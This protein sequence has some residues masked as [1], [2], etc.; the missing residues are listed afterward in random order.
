MNITKFGLSNFRV[1]KEHFD[2]DL[3]P[4]MV[5]TGPNNSGKSS[6]S[7]A[8]LLLKENE[9]EINSDSIF[10]DKCLNYFDGNHDL[11]HHSL[12]INTKEKHT[13]FSFT[14][15]LDYKFY[16]AF[17]NTG[18]LIDDYHISTF[19]GEL[20]IG[21]TDLGLEYNLPNLIKYF[22]DRI[23]HSQ[24]YQNKPAFQADINVNKIIDLVEKLK[25]ID[26]NS[27]YF[28]LLD[29]S[30]YEYD[31]YI[32]QNLLR[33]HFNEITSIELS[34]NEI[35]YL[36]PTSRRGFLSL[37]ELHYINTIKE[38]LKRAYS[39][40]DIS[41]FQ[42]LIMKDITKLG[43]DIIINPDKFQR[44]INI[45]NEGEKQFKSPYIFPR[46]NYDNFTQKWLKNFEIGEELSYGYDVQ[47]DIFYIKIDDVSLPEYG[48][49][50]G[51]II[52]VLLALSNEIGK[53]RNRDN[54][55]D[56]RLKFPPTYIIEE[57]ETGLHPAFQSKMAEML[58]DIQKT[59]N[60]NLIIETHSEY[61]IRKLQYLTAKN[62]VNSGDVVIYYFNNPKKVPEG[63]EQIKRI[64]ILKD[65]SLSDNFGPGFIDEGFNLK[66]ELLRLNKSQIN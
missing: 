29:D 12:I 35:N 58:V 25:S 47:N 2:F 62:E 31:D 21:Q 61:F 24:P 51:L 41:V 46:K 3:A 22:N 28:S 7:K 52:H 18:N 60:V 19:D 5:L 33:S 1:F 53:D 27:F 65:G 6:L 36:I 39:R 54:L 14:F 32:L 66:F 55:M 48:L 23:K 50:Y 16:L 13:L 37:S 64:T 56:F 20:V 49:G 63:E 38:P 44:R 34:V 15:F 10:F 11:G 59:F 45:N 30:D 40:N 26:A 43:N 8:L 4:I 9:G 42:S 57:P 17:D